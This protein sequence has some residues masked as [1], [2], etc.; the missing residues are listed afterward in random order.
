MSQKN[1]DKL[2]VVLSFLLFQLIE[3]EMFFLP[4][5]FYNISITPKSTPELFLLSH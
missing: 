5:L 2:V 3:C 1:L 4:G